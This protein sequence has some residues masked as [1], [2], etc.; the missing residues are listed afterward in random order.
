MTKPSDPLG[1]DPLHAPKRTAELLGVS[2]SWLAKSRMSGTGPRFVRVGRAIRYTET[3]LREYIRSR[4]YSSTS[5][6]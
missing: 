6:K 3:A 1:S 4:T 2:L 5:E